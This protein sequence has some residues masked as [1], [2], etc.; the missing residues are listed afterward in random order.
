MQKHIVR[1]M[2][3]CLFSKLLTSPLSFVVDL[4]F[5]S[6]DDVEQFLES[7]GFGQYKESFRTNS[8]DGGDLQELQHDGLKEL[9]VKPLHCSKIL[10]L[11]KQEKKK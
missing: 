2:V 8:I 11:I 10:K 7:N 5:M 3:C 1:A 6:V 4:S 9:G